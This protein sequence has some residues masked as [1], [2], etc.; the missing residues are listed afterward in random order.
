MKSTESTPAGKIT[1][2]VTATLRNPAL[3]TEAR[4]ALATVF[5][6]AHQEHPEVRAD[7]AV[8]V[9]LWQVANIAGVSRG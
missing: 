7:G 1:T 3:K 2:S 4:T 6:V 9:R 8:K 5:E